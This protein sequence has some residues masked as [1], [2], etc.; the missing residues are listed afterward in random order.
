L[1]SDTSWEKK[2][3]KDL[4]L[5]I[6]SGATPSGGKE[7]Y[8]TSG[9]S[10]I[11][12]Q[13]IYNHT[14]L[15]NGLAYIDDEQA[16]K[17]NNVDVQQDDVLLN[18]TGDSVCRCCIVPNEI[19][20]ARVNQHVAIIR[21]DQLKLN[22]FFLKS[23]LTNELMQNYM[24]S[25]AQT[26][27]TRAA[28]TKGMIEEFEL[29][30]PEL[31]EQARI[32]NTLWLLDKKIQ[33]NNAISKNLEEMA[34]ALF[35][36][37]FVDFDFSNENG[38]PYKSSGGE[39]E[40]SELG[41]IPKGWSYEKI[42]SIAVFKNGKGI[43]REKRDDIGK[44]KIMGSNGLIGFTNNILYNKPVIIIGRVGANYG[45]IH[46]LL[47][48]CWVSDNAIISQPIFEEDF[49][50]LLNI[51]LGV[52]YSNFVAG[53]AQPLITQTAIRSV[54]TIL[55]TREILHQFSL[56]VEDM[57][58]ALENKKIENETLS[59]LRDTLLPK[60]MS[61]EIRVPVEPEYTQAFDLPMVA[62]SSE[63]YNAH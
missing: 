46:Y 42:E 40:E 30:V 31:K 33:L 52:D 32:S 21:A 7:N 53:S 16:K 56:V 49:W 44:Y 34:Q 39:F 11:R 5:K 3:L 19:L 38:E 35:K 23:Y 50:F 48:P 15:S 13:N 62:E 17:L 41:S 2:K 4:C 54:T 14:F 10:L 18:I 9:I 26:G 47:E 59:K 45:E 61:G 22:P 27:G 63:K 25:L 55:P 29:P 60:L 1:I 6:G 37:W 12:S 8:K 20:P 24:Y 43:N 57:Y 36:R 58:L 51:L 28:L